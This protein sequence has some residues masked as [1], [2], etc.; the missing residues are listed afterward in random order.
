[1]QLSCAI[2]LNVQVCPYN[3]VCCAGKV[4]GIVNAVHE[5]LAA[6]YW[7]IRNGSNYSY[8]KVTVNTL[9]STLESLL[10]VPVVVSN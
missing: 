10:A 9:L 1:M 2:K 7:C 6:K 4:I 8:S 5:Y 3:D